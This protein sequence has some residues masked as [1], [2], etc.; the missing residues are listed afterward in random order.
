MDAGEP[1]G[2][3]MREAMTRAGAFAGRGVEAIGLHCTLG[4]HNPRLKWESNI[5]GTQIIQSLYSSYSREKNYIRIVSCTL[6][7]DDLITLVL[8]GL[9]PVTQ[10][11][12]EADKPK[13][14]QVDH[15]WVWI[16]ASIPCL[17]A[18]AYFLSI[19]LICL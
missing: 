10:L 12:L 14:S 3:G 1:G 13:S 9:L 18:A 4:G 8:R 11:I 19:Q 5:I 6:T 16:L 7:C 15:S 2:G 17:V